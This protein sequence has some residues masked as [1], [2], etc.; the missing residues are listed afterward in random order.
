MVEKVPGLRTGIP[1]S[2]EHTFCRLL[3]LLSNSV[4]SLHAK[5]ENYDFIF[6]E[7]FTMPGINKIQIFVGYPHEML[8]QQR[9][10]EGVIEGK[11]WKELEGQRL[12]KTK[13]L[14]RKQEHCASLSHYYRSTVTKQKRT[15]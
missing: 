10:R 14:E 11:R 5:T 6:S 1:I 3:W 8:P 2:H 15:L 4:N 12:R 9:E 13:T 7:S